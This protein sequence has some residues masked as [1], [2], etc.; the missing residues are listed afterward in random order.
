ME[1]FFFFLCR[2]GNQPNN[3]FNNKPA[4]TGFAQPATG[5]GQPAN[6]G[7]GGFGATATSQPISVFNGGSFGTNTFSFGQ[8]ATTAST[9]F[10]SIGAGS[11]YIS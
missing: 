8:P 10:G 6:T 3:L 11:K 5:F 7:F 2:F 9:G 1:L 4:A